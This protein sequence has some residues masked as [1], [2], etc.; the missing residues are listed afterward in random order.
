MILIQQAKYPKLSDMQGYGRPEK[1]LISPKQTL[2]QI[3]PPSQPHPLAGQCEFVVLSASGDIF[4]K[5]NNKHCNIYSRRLYV[6]M[7]KRDSFW[8]NKLPFS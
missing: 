8:E 6:S 2:P 4:M 1:D 3:L 5:E 7:E